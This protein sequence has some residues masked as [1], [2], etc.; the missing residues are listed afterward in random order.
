[1]NQLPGPRGELSEWLLAAL[2]QPVHALD[3]PGPRSVEDPL[4]DEDLHLCLYLCYELHYRGLPG[5]D[6]RWEW[7]PSL[8]ALRAAL[9][10]AFERALLKAV[11]MPADAIAPEEIDMALR[12]ISERDSPPLST[13]I[14]S[15][16]THEQVLEFL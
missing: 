9:E 13:Y 2:V 16:A 3:V 4:A 15:R 10:L 11:P 14:R 1:M 5:V 12:A 8:L 7:E 6:D